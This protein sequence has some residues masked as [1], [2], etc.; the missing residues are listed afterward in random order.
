MNIA[1]ELFLIAFGT[2]IG[3]V[4][5]ATIISIIIEKCGEAS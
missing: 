5:I 2:I 4:C 1:V 3:I